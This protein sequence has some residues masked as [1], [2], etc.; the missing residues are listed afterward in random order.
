MNS[1]RLEDHID[2]A[3]SAGNL[4]GHAIEAWLEEVVD[5]LGRPPVQPVAQGV[6]DDRLLLPLA[7]LPKR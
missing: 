3:A 5:L 6:V 2:I 7:L 4:A 1:A